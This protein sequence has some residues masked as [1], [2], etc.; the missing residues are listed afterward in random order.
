MVSNVM[1]TLVMTLLAT[2]LNILQIKDAWL[3]IVAGAVVLIV[4]ALLFIPLA[5]L[6]KLDLHTCGVA[7]IANI[8]GPS[9]A[10]I[11]AATY[12]RSYVSI[13]VIM[14]TLGCV[15]GTFV[16]LLVSQLLAVL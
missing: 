13:S 11:V 16:G 9:S 10:P 15:I 6:F 8:G 5:K 3:Y 7:S 2:E 12:H 4:H 14:A 1:L